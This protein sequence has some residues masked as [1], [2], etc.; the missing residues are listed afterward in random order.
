MYRI[1]LLSVGKTKEEWLDAAIQE[2][3]KRLQPI[4]SFESVWAKNDT[5]LISLAE[6][7]DAVICLDASGKMF[8]SE[9]FSSFLMDELTKGGSRLTFVIGG[10]EGLPDE[11]KRRY[12]LISLSKMTFTHQ[13]AR[14]LLV[15]QTYRAFEID[16]G[17]RYHK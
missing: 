8:D 12:P 2:Y 17:S 9:S 15:E 3:V 16:K 7:E 5:Q 11:M 13:M 4:A 1:K 10:A 14:L 6:K